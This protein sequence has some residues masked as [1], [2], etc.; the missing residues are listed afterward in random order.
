MKVQD[1]MTREFQSCRA[2]DS[3]NRAAQLMWEGDFG[4][5]PVVDAGGGVVGMITDRDICMAAYTRG[6]P[7]HELGVESAMAKQV[8]T[9]SEQSTI[10]TALFLMREARVRRLP[11]VDREGRLCGILSLSD[12]ARAE[13]ADGLGGA[14]TRTEIAAVLGCLSQPGFASPVTKTAAP[15]PTSRKVGR[16]PCA[17]EPSAV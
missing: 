4:V 15:R 6:R 9:C 11:I 7:L 12:L 16:L 17:A 1:C 2:G 5:V 13:R 8:A 10:E 3:L 14:R